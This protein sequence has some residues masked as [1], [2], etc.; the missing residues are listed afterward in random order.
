MMEAVALP[1]PRLPDGEPDW[2]VRGDAESKKNLISS[3]YLD[4]DL[5]ESHIK[6]LQKKYDEIERREIRYETYRTEDAEVILVAYGIVARIAHSVIDAARARG[7]RVG[8]FRPIT[9]WPFP[10]EALAEVAKGRRFLLTIELSTGQMVEDVKLITHG[11]CPV[12]F[13][14][15]V[16][17]NLP[18]ADEVLGELEKLLANDSES[19]G[20]TR[21][22]AR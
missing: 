6:H 3:I 2:A 10:K 21:G 19:G 4:H 14:G 7:I 1:E 16:G 18:S 11:I 17:G 20:A 12:H 5:L 8:L 9:L 22:G 13:Y 15:R